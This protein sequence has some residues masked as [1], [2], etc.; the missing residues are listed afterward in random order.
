MLWEL[1]H[2]KAGRGGDSG[3]AEYLIRGLGGGGSVEMDW[4]ERVNTRAYSLIHCI[5]LF[6]SKGL[7]VKN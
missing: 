2:D 7:Y 4:G 1:L 3:H 6:S 5:L